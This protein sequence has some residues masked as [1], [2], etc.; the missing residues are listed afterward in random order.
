MCVCVCVFARL[1]LNDN[2]HTDP[3]RCFTAVTLFL[4]QKLSPSVRPPPLPLRLSHVHPCPMSYSSQTLLCI[5]REPVKKKK[6]KK[7]NREHA[8]HTKTLALRQVYTQTH[9]P[10]THCSA[11]HSSNVSS[12]LRNKQLLVTKKKKVNHLG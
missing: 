10:H 8:A 4:T 6:E 9:T 1:H 5:G 7:K 12:H 11:K 3:E 2:R